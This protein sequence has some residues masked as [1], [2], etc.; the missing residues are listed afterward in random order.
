V[1]GRWSQS[2]VLFDRDIISKQHTHD[3]GVLVA[4]WQHISVTRN[5]SEQV[6]KTLVTNICT[7]G[8]EHHGQK[9]KQ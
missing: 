3:Q 2:K 4:Q 6:I 7:C 5:G 1:G 8:H 9:S